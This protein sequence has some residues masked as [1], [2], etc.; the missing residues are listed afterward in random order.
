MFW[1]KLAS[2]A[3][4]TPTSELGDA[5]HGLGRQKKVLK[6][7]GFSMFFLADGIS[8][9]HLAPLDAPKIGK[10]QFSS[11]KRKVLKRKSRKLNTFRYFLKPCPKQ[12]VPSFS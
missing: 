4:E 6:T 8:S 5:G 12:N 3:D 7:Q 1:K 2:R 11:I 9:D 10:H